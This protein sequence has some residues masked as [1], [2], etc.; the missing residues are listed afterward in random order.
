MDEDWTMISIK[1]PPGSVFNRQ[2]P[3]LFRSLGFVFDHALIGEAH[4]DGTTIEYRPI[5]APGAMERLQ[6]RMNDINKAFDA[7]FD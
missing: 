7:K 2:L 3:D 4:S 1:V 6:R 5:P